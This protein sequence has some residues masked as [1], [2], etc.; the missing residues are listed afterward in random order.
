MNIA[1]LLEVV[2]FF[3]VESFDIKLGPMQRGSGIPC[4]RNRI[5]VR[6]RPEV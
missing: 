6:Y 4:G 2:F 5:A 3:V 1:N